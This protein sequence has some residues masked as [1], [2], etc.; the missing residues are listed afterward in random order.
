M[1]PEEN[2]QA[3]LG[4]R[5]TGLRVIHVDEEIPTVETAAATLGVQ[6]AQ[7]AKILAIRAKDRVLL[8]VTRGDA[9]VDNI[10]FRDQ[11]GSRPRMLP[12]AEAQEFTGQPVGGV[13]PFGHPDTTDVYCD[14]SLRAFDAVY[15][16]GG[17]RSSAVKVAPEQ[18]SEIVG[19]EWVDVTK[20]P[21]G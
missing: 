2:V 10:K 19:A 18:L 5:G 7:I 11:F 12:R 13:S 21:E 1:S 14:E 15:P 4:A 6:P 9:R 17:S 3:F 8:V 20:V 16:S